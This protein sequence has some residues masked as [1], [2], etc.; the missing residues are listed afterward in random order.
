MAGGCAFVA[1]DS[2]SSWD[3]VRDF[4]ALS[5]PRLL[6]FCP[7]QRSFLYPLDISAAVAAMTLQLSRCCFLSMDQFNVGTS[8]M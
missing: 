5:S 6:D 2:T 8:S 7:V 1:L 4:P 3:S